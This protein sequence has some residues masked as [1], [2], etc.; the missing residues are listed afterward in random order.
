[1]S[2]TMEDA[3]AK[4]AKFISLLLWGSPRQRAIQIM[5]VL[6]EH[7]P[8]YDAIPESRRRVALVEYILDHQDYLTDTIKEQEQGDADRA[9]GK[10]RKYFKK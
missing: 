2:P 10:N 6:F 5:G 4:E 1:M 7:M 8:G 9:S 3:E